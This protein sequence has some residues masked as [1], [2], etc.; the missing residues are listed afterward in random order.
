M[1]V[2]PLVVIAVLSTGCTAYPR[3]VSGSVGY[4]VIN[5]RLVAS[6]CLYTVTDPQIWISVAP[7]PGGSV[8]VDCAP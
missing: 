1:R 5:N 8:R 4:D 3:W 7:T 2:A 6:A